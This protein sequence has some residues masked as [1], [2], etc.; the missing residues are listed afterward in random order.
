MDNSELF[1]NL[2][3]V[4]LKMIKRKKKKEKRER[5]ISYFI[6][7]YM[8]Y[9]KIDKY[10]WKYRWNIFVGKFWRDF[11]DRNIPSVYTDGIK[12]FFLKKITCHFYQWNYRQKY[13]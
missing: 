6:I 1:N 8:H 5:L 3:D 12:F 7:C 11:T 13:R 10:K 9:Q 4:P 2:L